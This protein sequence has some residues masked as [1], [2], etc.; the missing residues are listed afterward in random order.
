MN[1]TALDY[2][3]DVSSLYMHGGTSAPKGGTSQTAAL[4][5][6]SAALVSGEL[7]TSYGSSCLDVAGTS[8]DLISGDMT[9]AFG[10]SCL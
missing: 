6:G 5:M 4:F 1:N 7:T 9:H 8:G 10:S 2:S 3:H